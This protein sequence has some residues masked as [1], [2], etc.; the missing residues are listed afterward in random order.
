MRCCQ[1]SRA[2]YII[3]YSEAAT[4]AAERQETITDMQRRQKDAALLDEKYIREQA[5]HY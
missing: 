5:A 3:Q 4:L 2:H 1:P